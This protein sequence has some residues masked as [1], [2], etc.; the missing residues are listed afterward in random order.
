MET[1]LSSAGR[2]TR[3]GVRCYVGPGEPA[4]LRREDHQRIKT[5]EANGRNAKELTA[6]MSYP[7]RSANLERVDHDVRTSARRAREGILTADL[8]H[9]VADI[10][11]QCRSPNRM[12]GFAAPE[13]MEAGATPGQQRFGSED[14]RSVEQVREKSLEPDKD[15]PIA[16]VQPDPRWCRGFKPTSW[17]RRNDL[18]SQR[19]TDLNSL[20]STP[21]MSF[22]TSVVLP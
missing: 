22:K 2:S 4:P 14:E 7:G 10:G 15:R 5:F 11:R 19:C 13:P 6:A 9:Q 16:I 1:L 3:R 17:R 20:T 8:P 18:R 12:P 21:P